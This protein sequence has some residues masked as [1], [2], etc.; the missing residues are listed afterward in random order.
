[1]AARTGGQ[2]MLE[3]PDDLEPAFVAALLEGANEEVPASPPFALFVRSQRDDLGSIPDVHDFR[4]LAMFRQG[5]RLALAFASDNSAM[6]TYSSVY[7]LLLSNGF[8][9]APDG[10]GGAGV[11]GLEEFAAVIAEVLQERTEMHG[12]SPDEY[13]AA[14]REV[15]LF[16]ARAHEAAGNGQSS[17]AANWWLHVGDW[18]ESLALPVGSGEAAGVPR[19]YGCAGMPAPSNGN[20][21]GMTPKEYVAVLKERWSSPALIRAE[22]SRL[23]GV[24][25]AREAAA[26]LAGLDWEQSYSVAS[27][28]TD[29]PVSWV[30][31]A[32]HLDRETR[33]RSWSCLNEEDFLGSRSDAPGRLRIL[34]GGEEL[35]VPWKGAAPVIIASPDEVVPGDNRVVELGRVRLVIPLQGGFSPK[36][37][38]SDLREVVAGVG[39]GGVKGC[40]VEFDVGSYEVTADGLSLDGTLRIAPSKRAPNSVAIEAVSTGAAAGVLA[41]RCAAVFTLVRP[42]EVALW[43]RRTSSGSRA[44]HRGPVVWARSGSE[45][46]ELELPGP[47]KYEVV[48]V[49]GEHAGTPADSWLAGTTPVGPWPGFEQSVAREVLDV[50]SGLEVTNTGQ[51]IFRVELG[52][53]RDRP[54]SPIVA[55]ANGVLPD[56][57]RALGDETLTYLEGILGECLN[58]LATGH[59]LGCAL[60]TDM[61]TRKDLATIAPGVF[62]TPGLELRAYQ[63]SP[64]LPSPKLLEH[65]EYTRLRHAYVGLGVSSMIR[66]LEEKEGTAGLTVSRIPLD[67]IPRSRIEELLDAYRALLA[68]TE[69]LGACDKFWAR[70]P[71]S[72]VVFPE[73]AGLQAARAALLSPLHPIRLAWSWA[74][75]VGLRGACDDGVDAAAS[76]A[77]LD[78]T[79]FPAYTLIGDAFGA[80]TA[81]M[82]I[83]VDAHPEDVYLGWHSSVALIAGVPVIPEWLAGRR[84]P[85]DGLSALSASSVGAAIDDFLRVSPHVQALRL[86]LASTGPAR[87]SSAI[88]DGVLDKLQDIA[89]CS[90][91]LDGVGGVQVR[92]STYRLGT[93]PRLDSLADALASARPGFNAQ[94]T[95]VSPGQEVGSHLAILEGSAAQFT[96]AH[97]TEPS[98]GW[99]PQLPLRRTPHRARQQHVVVLDYA[100]GSAAAAA[101]RLGQVLRE[102]EV[103]PG[104]QGFV[105]KVIPNL[106]GITGRPNWLV[107]ADFGIDPQTLSRAATGQAGGEY[108]LWDWRPGAAVRPSSAASGRV[109]PYF[110][111]AAL[112]RAL[113]RAICERLRQLR[114]DISNDEIQR[115]T[116]LL[117]ST[118]AERAIGLNTLLAIG[119]HQATGALGFYFALRSLATWMH[120]GTDADVRLVVPVDAVDPFIRASAP[121]KRAQ[122][123][124]RADLLA[125]RASLSPADKVRLVLSPIEIKHYGLSSGGSPSRFPLAGEPRLEKHVEQLNDYQLQ[126]AEFCEACRTAVGGKASV[127]AQ[128]LAALVDAAIQLA[129]RTSSEVGRLLAS[130]SS[131]AAQPELGKGILAWYQAG[132]TGLNGQGAECDEVD[133]SLETRRVDVRIDPAAFDAEF[134]GA[135]EGDC[136]AMMCAAL[137]SATEFDTDTADGSPDAGGGRGSRPMGV[138][139]AAQQDDQVSSR[140]SE[141]DNGR[142]VANDVA[143]KEAA[144][145][146]PQAHLSGADPSEASP[147]VTG[148]PVPGRLSQHELESRYKTLLAA[149]G[150]FGVK[151]ERP[152]GQGAYQ[153][154]PG[155]VEFAVQPAYGVSVSRV[156]AQMENLKLRLRLPADAVIG[157]STH[158]GNIL[159]TAPKADSERYYVDAGEMWSRWSPPQSGFVIPLGEDISGDIVTLDLASSN[160]PHVLI[161]GATGSGKSEALLTILHG[162]A[163]HNSPGELQLLLV[164]PKQTELTS[165]A[166]LPHTKGDVGWTGED[167]IKVLDEAVE[168]MERRYASFKAAGPGVRSI[169]EFRKT[170]GEL[171]RWLLVLDE[172]ADLVSDDADRVAI[173]RS[174]KRLSQKARAAGIHILVSTQ[175]PVATVVNTVVKGNLPGRIA[176][177]VT[178]ATESRVVL[179]EGGAEQLV[180]KG[181]AIVKTGNSRRRVQFAR[182]AL[183]DD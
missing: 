23:H 11:G 140:G 12:L 136:H 139:A 166:G 175:K 98:S 141:P 108:V 87:R 67:Q 81:L 99:L 31:A 101:S 155:F 94:W 128:R 119:H 42:D 36:D 154:G 114:A 3:L 24:A 29:S 7:P 135:G 96:Y 83:P 153:E 90:T 112:P 56:S 122:S 71:F 15:L 9:A 78:G 111:L 142:S 143:A 182:Y 51:L 177:R 54:L 151:V 97:L 118:L 80:T 74:V 162:A 57:R 38:P 27:V 88:D 77:L 150:E 35:P 92:D 183:G 49:S 107:A 25:S 95:S 72:V 26:S 100:L 132:A 117:V 63:L 165:L 30:A 58:S 14:V 104:G 85:V 115:R 73:G 160:S 164:D 126:L 172:Y 6:A 105:L 129:P 171:P 147:S 123:R 113:N 47:A 159:L 46:V 53:V 121:G 28:R 138:E 178:S 10:T 131:G 167:A 134:W 146:L 149:L 20:S 66:V 125:I 16:L 64:G 41:G 40:P 61:R 130:I 176:F 55:A 180:G 75:Q 127:L 174:I 148:T 2:V 1:M 34:R 59:A 120:R 44:L 62:T 68:N 157:C 4:E 39:V 84:F 82:P 109:Q 8:P 21:L 168:E 133:G 93:A 124:R 145:D 70:H 152:R 79:H 13:G 19:L 181:D 18:T 158:L 76:L 22:L 156:E 48:L 144:P 33:A 137:D 89:L 43:A 173:E 52:D 102:Y 179:D 60:A 106:A 91:R 45:E 163:R 103:S 169:A 116:R 32:S 37:L 170:G 69:D 161:A 50:V 86:G 65:P 17:F 5:A 110:I